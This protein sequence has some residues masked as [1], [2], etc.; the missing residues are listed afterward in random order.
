MS[1][2]FV[3]EQECTGGGCDKPTTHYLCGDCTTSLAKTM[4]DIP[5]LI[6]V[7]KLIST[8]I[9]KAF[10]QK[11]ARGGGGGKAGSKPPMNLNAYQLALNLNMALAYTPHQYATHQDGAWSKQYI[12]SQAKAAKL[13][14]DG[15]PEVTRTEWETRLKLQGVQPMPARHLIPWFKEKLG[16]TIHAGTLRQWVFLK[17]IQKIETGGHPAYDPVEVLKEYERSKR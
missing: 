4:S 11:A 8:N 16:V 7:L 14:V 10:T 3:Y 2:K 15:E 1:E 12:E 13:L 5:R 6:E 17:K 9:E